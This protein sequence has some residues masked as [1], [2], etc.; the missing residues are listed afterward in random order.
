M[1]VRPHLLT[2]WPVCPAAWRIEVLCLTWMCSDFPL[3][4]WSLNSRKCWVSV[5]FL[6]LLFSLFPSLGVRANL[7]LST[8]SYHCAEKSAADRKKKHS[9]RLTVQPSDSLISASLSKIL[10]LI[11]CSSP[12][13]G[14][15]YQS[16]KLESVFMEISET[17]VWKN[18]AFK[19][20]SKSETIT[21]NQHWL[22]VT[23]TKR[24]VNNLRFWHAAWLA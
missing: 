16:Q 2:V 4:D 21:E 3:H 10:K 13:A 8:Y 14:I 6:L 1:Y 11:T 19:G 24:S 23:A 5:F 20:F 7:I 22:W 18:K 9:H 15:V 12:K 17:S